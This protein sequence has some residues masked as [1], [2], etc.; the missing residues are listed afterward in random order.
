MILHK[1]TI[2]ARLSVV[3]RT[4]YLKLLIQCNLGFVGYHMRFVG[5][6]VSRLFQ[7]CNCHGNFKSRKADLVQRQRKIAFQIYSP[8]ILAIMS[9]VDF[10]Q[11]IEFKY[12]LS[13]SYITLQNLEVYRI[14]EP[15]TLRHMTFIDVEK[16]C[17]YNVVQ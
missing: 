8:T 9:T 2:I 17:V 1:F 14:I 12:T 15:I 10:R 13:I 5:Y 4:S 7:R 16:R 3:N 6:H 11:S